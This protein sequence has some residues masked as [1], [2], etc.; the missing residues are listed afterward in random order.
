MRCILHGQVP[1][2]PQLEDGVVGAITITFLTAGELKK[3]YQYRRLLHASVVQVSKLDHEQPINPSWECWTCR[4]GHG[5]MQ[6]LRAVIYANL[7]EN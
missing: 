2:V 5:P 7:K 6:E 3:Q 4:K 1:A